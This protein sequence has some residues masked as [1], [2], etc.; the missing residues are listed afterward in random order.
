MEYNNFKH[1]QAGCDIYGD[2]RLKLALFVKNN[3]FPFIDADWFLENGTLLGA[4]RDSKFIKH[5]DDFDVAVIIN[6]KSD[7]KQ[8]LNI[9]NTNLEKTKY[10]ARL[11]ETYA[12]KI[13]IYDE[14][15]GKY[16]L[17]SDKY[18][19]ADF[20]YVTLDLQFYLKNNTHYEKLY[21]IAPL[22]LLFAH[23]TLLPPSQIILE[24]KSFNAPANVENFLQQQYGS[25][26]PNATYNSTTGLY[27]TNI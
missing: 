4:W 11:I 22:K 21:Y 8:L 17:V 5:D 16:K 6:N 12:L 9:I 27:E 10:K 24:G 20:H 3:I 1:P 14:S 19:G 13:E 23:N 25:L 2:E 26:A 7:V 18:N 15:Y